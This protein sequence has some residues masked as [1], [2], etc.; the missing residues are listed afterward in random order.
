MKRRTF[1]RGATAAGVSAAVPL[2]SAVNA[3]GEGPS[4]PVDRIVVIGA[5]IVGSSIAWNLAKRGADVVLLDMS[6]PASQASGNSFAWINASWY[7]Q[8]DSYFWLRTHSLNEYHRLSKEAGFPVHWGGSLEWYHTEEAQQEMAAGV[9][10]IQESGAPAWMIDRERAAVIEPELDPQWNGR[11]A[12]CSRDGAV[13]PGIATHALVGGVINNGG[14]AVFPVTAT[15]IRTTRT[16]VTVETDA[17]SFEADLVVIA[18]GIHTNEVAA[19]AGIDTTL[20][21]PPTPGIIVTTRP[22]ER[23]LNAV[24]YTTDSHFHQLPDGRVIVGEKAGPPDTAEHLDYVAG[25]PNVYPGAELA[26]QHAARVFETAGQY[27]SGLDKAEIERVGVGWR[28]LPVDGLPVIGH[29]PA[30]PRVY[31]AAMHSGVTLA[32]IVGHLA[33]MEILDR[34]RMNLLNHFRIERLE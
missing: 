27:V 11:L 15:S 10:R 6:G 3:Q 24:S 16:G 32:P 5:G 14:Q 12:W 19:M 21:R 23:W 29:V 34:I 20:L 8:P 7:D 17:G 26:Q 1:L 18:A 4:A 9:S 28:P 31:L 25:R 33:A 30:Y 13:D 22:M 2:P